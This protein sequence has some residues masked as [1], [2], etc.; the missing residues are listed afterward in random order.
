VKPPN[1]PLR[2]IAEGNSI[3]AFFNGK[4]IFCGS[5]DYVR[6]FFSVHFSTY[7]NTR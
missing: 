2:Y 5:K 7:K 3:G 6:V 1:F 4:I